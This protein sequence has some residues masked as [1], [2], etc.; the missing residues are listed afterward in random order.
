M[1]EIFSSEKLFCIIKVEVSLII[2]S[3]C[4]LDLLSFI[5]STRL[6]I[7]PSYTHPKSFLETKSDKPTFLETITA[8]PCDKDSSTVF[9]KFSSFDGRINTS[10][11]A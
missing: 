10:A 9:A 5:T 6:F 8:V 11:F 2:F 3:F 1:L 7:E 4:G